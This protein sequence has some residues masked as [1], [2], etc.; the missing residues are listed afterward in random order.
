MYVLEWTRISPIAIFFASTG[1]N[2]ADLPDSTFIRTG[3][4]TRILTAALPLAAVEDTLAG[5]TTFPR[6]AISVFMAHADIH[7]LTVYAFLVGAAGVE[8]LAAMVVVDLRIYAHR[9]AGDKAHVPTV[10]AAYAIYA[11]VHF[12]ALV[13]TGSAVIGIIVK[14]HALAVTIGISRRTN[15]L[16]VHAFGVRAALISALAAVVLVIRK[17]YTP[18]PAI[19]LAFRAPGLVVA[20]NRDK[21]QK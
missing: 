1:R 19:R 4:S 6:H 17:I 3:A 11:V 20:A 13:S 8:A 10:P 12:P 21:R 9:P 15:A 5:D 2:I 7:A 14:V 16:A 18:G